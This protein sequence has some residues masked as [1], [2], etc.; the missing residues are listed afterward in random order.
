MPAV[1][2][3]A[4]TIADAWLYMYNLESACQIQIA[5]QAGGSELIMLGEDVIRLNCES[6]MEVTAGQG[7]QIAWAAMLDKVERK[8]PSFRD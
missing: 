3:A 7:G 8:D 4:P 1:E 2:F 6:V 5:A